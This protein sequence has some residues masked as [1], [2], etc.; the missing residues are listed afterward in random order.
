MVLVFTV[1]AYL[2]SKRST[3][4]GLR[5]LASFS[6]AA[7]V[8]AGAMAPTT[9]LTADQLTG[10]TSSTTT[11]GTAAATTTASNRP[12]RARRT[13]RTPSQISTASLPMYMK[14]PGEQELVIF[15]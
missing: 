3:T 4:G 10:N 9:E 7:A 1:S 14:E 6:H 13:Q 8:G 5:I 11:N 2:W 15:R 12:R